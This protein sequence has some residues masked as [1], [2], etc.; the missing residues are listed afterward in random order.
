[1]LNLMSSNRSLVPVSE[2]LVDQVWKD[3]PAVS[4][5]NLIRLPDRVIREF[6]L[7]YRR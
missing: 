1:M 2:N 5:E 7:L 3:R 6:D 4:P